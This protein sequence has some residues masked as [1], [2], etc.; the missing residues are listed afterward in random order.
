LFDKKSP[1]LY[2]V[3]E[4]G[5]NMF[6]R[7]EYNKKYGKQWR[8]DNPEYVREYNR[9]W[10]KDNL[11]RKREYNRKWYKNNSEHIKKIRRQQYLKNHGKELKQRYY[12]SNHERELK[13]S[14]QYRK[15]HFEE[16]KQR[17]ERRIKIIQNYKLSK[18]CLFCGYN[19]D[20]K[21]LC[22][23]HPDDNKEFGVSDAVPG[24]SLKK[25]K[26]EMDK[27]IILCRSCHTKLHNEL[28]K[29]KILDKNKKK[30]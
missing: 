7:K 4:G 15:D 8:K 2:N 12:Y 25:I 19:E 16:I 5:D 1:S 6:N 20:P 29:L 3:S 11:E 27:C 21:S 18:G 14:A 10:S 13:R 28:R 22:F 30:V 23:H 26:K 24:M 9:K 17:R